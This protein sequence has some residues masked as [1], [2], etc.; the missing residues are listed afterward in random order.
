VTISPILFK[1][2]SCCTQIEFKQKDQWRFL[3]NNIGEIANLTIYHWDPESTW[4]FESIII[5]DDK[6]SYAFAPDE[7]IPES[8]DG[9]VPGNLTL[10]RQ[11]FLSSSLSFP[12]LFNFLP[13][14]PFSFIIKSQQHFL[15]L[16]PLHLRNLRSRRRVQHLQLHPWS[17]IWY[18]LSD[19]YSSS[20][21]PAL[22]PKL[23]LSPFFSQVITTLNFIRDP[24]NILV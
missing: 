18:P 17:C 9:F 20:F 6:K 19:W 13:L 2:K 16:E 8:P 1:M 24:R 12:S 14:T 5:A 4:F 7:S 22:I 15:L 3:L 10:T 21:I 23:I 11:F